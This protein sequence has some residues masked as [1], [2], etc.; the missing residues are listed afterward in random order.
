[1]FGDTFYMSFKN[2]LKILLKNI[3]SNRSNRSELFTASDDEDVQKEEFDEL[4][5]DKVATN[6]GKI[7]HIVKEINNLNGCNR[8]EKIIL[9]FHSKVSSCY[10]KW[11]RNFV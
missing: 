4:G 2:I 10:D 1:M 5:F 11:F 9:D 3:N 7:L 6:E 8:I